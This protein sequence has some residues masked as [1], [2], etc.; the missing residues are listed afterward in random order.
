MPGSRLKP[1][2]SI[3]F[4]QV[5]RLGSRS[6]I[7]TRRHKTFPTLDP[8][9]IERLRRFGEIRSH[10]ATRRWPRSVKWATAW[11]SSRPPA[12]YLWWAAPPFSLTR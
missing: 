12:T 7:E 1:M 6:I 4:G 11:T 3:A 9:E 5:R 8:A 2:W 10:G